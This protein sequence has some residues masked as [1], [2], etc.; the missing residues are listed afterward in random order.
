MTLTGRLLP[1][2]FR[3]EVPSSWTKIDI[4]L[5]YY[6]NICSDRAV[7]LALLDSPWTA[8]A[9]ARKGRSGQPF[10]L[11]TSTEA[12]RMDDAGSAANDSVLDLAVANRRWISP[13]LLSHALCRH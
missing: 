9:E 6:V 5:E 3:W 13:R 4:D 11:V 1:G 2:P 12:E 7:S 8:Q 10:P